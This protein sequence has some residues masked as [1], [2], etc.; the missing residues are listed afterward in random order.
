MLKLIC[1]ALCVSLSL[2][3]TSCATPPPNV[4]VCTEITPERGSCVMTMTGKEFIVD[5]EHPYKGKTWWEMRVANLQM[6]VAS[7][8]EIKSW[9]IKV[10]KTNKNMCDKAVG[11]WDRTLGTV[12]TNIK[13][14]APY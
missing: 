10:C 1:A 14:K 4:P 13:K 2:L 11:S 7:W 12:D 3:L 5:E 6:P 8:V 9:I